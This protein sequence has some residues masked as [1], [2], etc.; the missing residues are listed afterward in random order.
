MITTQV[1]ASKDSKDTIT[2]THQTQVLLTTDFI[3]M[4]FS[5]PDVAPFAEIGIL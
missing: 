3:L 2:T 1:T 5:P 4:F